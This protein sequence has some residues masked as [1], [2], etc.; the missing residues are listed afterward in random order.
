M[1][2]VNIKYFKD[3]KKKKVEW[4]WFPY[5]AYGKITILQGDPGDGKTTLALFIASM[6]SNGDNKTLKG[7]NVDKPQNV[8]YQTNEDGLEDTVKPRL[9]KMNANCKNIAY[10]EDDI[11]LNDEKLET[12]IKKANAKLVIL[13][14]IQ[15]FIN[16]GMQNVGEVRPIMKRLAKIALSTNCAMLLI[17]HLN[18][19]ENGKDLYR[20]LGSIDFSAIARSVL[21]LKRDDTDSSIRI[22]NQIK[23]NVG[24]EGE[25]LSIRLCDDKIEMV[26]SQNKDIDEIV[27]S[28]ID[29]TEIAKKIIIKMISNNDNEAS[30]IY[31][32][33]MNYEI[34]KRTVDIA[35]KELMVVSKKVNNKWLWIM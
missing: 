16:G 31:K 5:I 23:N 19:K 14:P 30:S 1:E 34:S 13:D 4:L 29:K 21:Y 20:G 25:I 8:I 9:E 17:G 22:L 28:K 12:A 26:K 18:K 24:P 6:V 32:V 33:C 15:S 10:I 3:V 2:E 7:L 27:N 35:K 11:S